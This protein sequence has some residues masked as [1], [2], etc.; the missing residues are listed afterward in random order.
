MLLVRCT[1]SFLFDARFRIAASDEM[2]VG[3]CIVLADDNACYV[4]RAVRG[5]SAVERAS[6]VVI[7]T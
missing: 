4:V 7:R 6:N 2:E 3:V 1:F 5:I